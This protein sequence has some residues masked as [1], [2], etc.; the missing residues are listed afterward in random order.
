MMAD[1]GKIK[2]LYVFV[3]GTEHILKFLKGF[4]LSGIIGII[5]Q[6]AHIPSVIFPIGIIQFHE[7]SIPQK[8]T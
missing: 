1:K 7:Y 4:P 5:V 8:N 3:E 2:G 6:M